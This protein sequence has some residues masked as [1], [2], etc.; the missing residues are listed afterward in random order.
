MI[1]MYE[2]SQSNRDH[3]FGSKDLRSSPKS[4]PPLLNIL[5]Q[6]EQDNQ[7]FHIN[8]QYLKIIYR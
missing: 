2:N 4:G 8:T 3:S 7:Y 5:N 1:V 6:V